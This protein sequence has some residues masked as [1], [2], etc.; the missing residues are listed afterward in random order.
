MGDMNYAELMAKYE[1]M[2]YFETDPV[3]VVRRFTDVMDIEVMGLV[4]SWLALGNRNQ[5]YKY[6]CA[7]YDLMTGKPYKYVI[8]Q[9]WTKYADDDRCYY[10]MFRYTDFHDLMQSL[11]SIYTQFGTLEDAIIRYNA[12]YPGTDYLDALISLISAHGIPTSKSS[13]CKRLCLLLR[14]MV[15]RDS[16]IDL[17]IWTRLDQKKLLIPLDVHVGRIARGHGL[18]KRQSSDMKAV[19]ELT[20]QCRQII[21][22]DPCGMDFALFGM[23]Y[24]SK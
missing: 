1:D 3:A 23:G 22:D 21:P 16:P 15:R 14:W 24:T 8:S 20:G 6:C 19:L 12:Q 11:Y 10:R 18:L 13:A 4:C 9:A 7:S 5:I 17:G 2:R